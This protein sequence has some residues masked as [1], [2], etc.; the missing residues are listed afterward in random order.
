MLT[1]AK[2]TG[3]KIRDSHKN[4]NMGITYLYQHIYGFI[5]KKKSAKTV[6]YATVAKFYL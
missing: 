3:A 5:K 1:D 6:T 2:E 4:N